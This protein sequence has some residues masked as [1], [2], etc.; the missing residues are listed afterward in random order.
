MTQL[1][2]VEINPVP[3][4]NGFTSKKIKAVSSS[5][6]TLMDYCHNTFGKRVGS[7]PGSN[8]SDVYYEIESS[9]IVIVQ[10]K[11]TKF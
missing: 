1:Q 5:H 3:D 8:E 11:I 4:G 10:E 6:S 9:D 7:M 2:L